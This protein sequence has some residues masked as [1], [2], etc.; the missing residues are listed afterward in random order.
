MLL[1]A[2]SVTHLGNGALSSIMLGL[3]LGL[4]LIPSLDLNINL[5]STL[6]LTR[7][8]HRLAATILLEPLGG[9]RGTPAH[10][11]LVTAPLLEP[12]ACAHVQV[13]VQLGRGLLAMDKVTEAAAHTA[14]AAVEATAGFSEIR[15]GGE[16]AID[17]AAGV[18]ARVER[19]ARLLRVFLVLE[20]YIDVADEV[21]EVMC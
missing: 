6:V 10:A 4:R 8:T 2:F 7:H 18:P 21:C 1:F 11:P 20:A 15:H 3:G 9:R 12:L 14:L 5:I 17:G 19:I 13:A 16:L